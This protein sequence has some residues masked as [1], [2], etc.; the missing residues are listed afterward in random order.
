M[1]LKYIFLMHTGNSLSLSTILFSLRRHHGACC[2]QLSPLF[3]NELEQLLNQTICSMLGP[4]TPVVSTCQC[5]PQALPAS[6]WVW[7]PVIEQV[8]LSPFILIK[9]M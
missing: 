4:L 7:P 1:V 2:E 5:W 8:D 6:Y 9:Y 3:Q